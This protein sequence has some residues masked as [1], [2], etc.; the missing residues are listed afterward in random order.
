MSRRASIGGASGAS[1]PSS[2]RWA[3]RR[4]SAGAMMSA[5][6]IPVAGSSTGAVGA[7]LADD[8]RALV[9]GVQRVGDQHLQRRVLVLDDDDLVQALGE[10]AH[11]LGVERDRQ[12]EVQQPDA[13]VAD[14]LGGLQSDEGQRL[15]RLAVR[16]A[17]CSDADPG[18]RRVDG[19]VVEV[20]VDAVAA[21]QVEA[22][23]LELALHV[24]RVRRQQPTRR[25]R[26]RT[27][28]RRSPPSARSARSARRAGRRC[29]CRRRPRRR[30]SST[31]RDRWPATARRRGGRDR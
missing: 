6:S 26:A 8:H 13:G 19:D 22:D 31:S 25:L 21:G 2:R 1:R 11:D 28:S 27:A 4:R 3:R 5:S 24:E 10:A 7:A 17:R 9:R 20:V 12:A 16:V 18:V 23:L 30:S 15:E 29:R 14:L